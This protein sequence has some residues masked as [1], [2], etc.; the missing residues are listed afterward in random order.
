M[1][2]RRYEQNARFTAGLVTAV[3]PPGIS[4]GHGG[5]E[6]LK[7]FV[8]FL[9]QHGGCLVM[10]AC[11]FFPPEPDFDFWP[12]MGRHHPVW[13]RDE[14]RR[15]SSRWLPL[16]L[17]GEEPGEWFKG[18]WTPVLKVVAADRAQDTADERAAEH[19]E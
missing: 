11:L 9:K 8:L 16:V 19:D 5:Y 13:F 17:N 10:N 1:P 15:S 18:D 14:K 7:D 6:N 3:F 2:L 12:A 4:M